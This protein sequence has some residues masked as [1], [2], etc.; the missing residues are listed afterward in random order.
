MGFF[1]GRKRGHVR[2]RM[3]HSVEDYVA[4]E[5]YDLPVDIADRY[6]ARGYAEGSFS[7]EYSEADLIALR[8]NGQIAQ[9]V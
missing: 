2:V 5:Q 6:L 8:G 4:G 1:D 3:T 7:R 9:V